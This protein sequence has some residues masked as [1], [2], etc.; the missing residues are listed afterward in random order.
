MEYLLRHL[1]ELKSRTP[2]S[3]PRLW[4]CVNNAWSK[5]TKYYELT[6]RSHQIYATATFL[7]PTQ[8]RDFFDSA[9]VGKLQ[10]WVEIMLANCRDIWERDYAHLAPHKKAKQ[11]DAF[12]E[13]L[14]RRKEEDTVADEFRRYPIA[15]SAI[16]ATERFDPIAWW[17]RPDREE[18]FLT[19]QRWAFDIFACPATS[20]ECERAFSRCEEAHYPRE[21]F[22]R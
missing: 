7:N 21:D 9:W 4:E 22:S 15:G 5:M 10:P 11:R 6:D 1:E 16:P 3:E 12:E 2:Q 18:A 14:Y 19:L 17:S 20:C 13:W 8:R